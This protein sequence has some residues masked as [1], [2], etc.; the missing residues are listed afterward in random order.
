MSESTHHS[1]GGWRPQTILPSLQFRRS[2]GRLVFDQLLQRLGRNAE[3]MAQQE[4]DF[5]GFTLIRY[6]IHIYIY[7]YN[8]MYI[9][10][11]ISK[12]ELICIHYSYKSSPI[13]DNIYRCLILYECT[14]YV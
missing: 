1:A 4:Q 10:I 6:Y 9:Y 13:Q 14:C 11:Y 5:D 2:L 8:Y 12:E 7:N 3:V